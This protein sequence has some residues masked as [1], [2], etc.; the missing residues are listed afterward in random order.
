MCV[1][2]FMEMSTWR[3]VLIPR[4]TYRAFSLHYVKEGWDGKT[5]CV[6]E[7]VRRAVFDGW[8]KGGGGGVIVADAQK[9]LS[10]FRRQWALSWKTLSRFHQHFEQHSIVLAKNCGLGAGRAAW[11]CRTD[12]C[13]RPSLSVGRSCKM[14]RQH[15]QQELFWT[16]CC[17]VARIN[18][19]TEDPNCWNVWWKYGRY[20]LASYL[21]SIGTCLWRRKAQQR[22]CW[23][24]V[25]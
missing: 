5:N 14:A 19:G 17:P 8:G 25:L 7:M 12:L 21:E 11:A 4:Q 20:V 18:H 10:S 22:T 13:L 1:Q 23:A 9:A 6:A 24:C 16:S 15:A 3:L 2:R